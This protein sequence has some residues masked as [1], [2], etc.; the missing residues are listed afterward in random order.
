MYPSDHQASP[1][2]T[3]PFINIGRV[4]RGPL[5]SPLGAAGA[6]N[7]IELFDDELARPY[8]ARLDSNTC[9]SPPGMRI[10]V[11]D[12]PHLGTSTEPPT[13][14]F[15]PD[16]SSD[17]DNIGQLNGQE[18][19]FDDNILPG[20]AIKTIQRLDKGLR[21]IA[22]DADNDGDDGE[23]AVDSETNTDDIGIYVFVVRPWRRVLSRDSESNS[24]TLSPAD[25]RN[26]LAVT[27]RRHL[28]RRNHLALPA[29]SGFWQSGFWRFKTVQLTSRL[30]RLAYHFTYMG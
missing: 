21:S 2:L 24:Y 15:A 18:I 8:Q 19:G 23:H 12:E 1:T 4:Y 3:S 20:F 26:S 7:L 6:Q 22:R 11:I 16:V 5:P 27:L 29:L 10:H 25:T 14:T 13:E 30:S 17:G 28:L 9:A